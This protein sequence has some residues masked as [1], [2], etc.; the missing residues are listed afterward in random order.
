[1]IP[2]KAFKKVSDNGNTAV[3]KHENGHEIHIVKASLS[4]PLKKQ[5]QEM[6][7]HSADGN[8]IPKAED[9]APTDVAQPQPQEQGLL[10]A[11]G[12]QGTPVPPPPPEG[13]TQGAAIGAV[14]GTQNLPPPDPFN[15][16]PG[17]QEQAQAIP[18]KES[19]ISDEGK[20][21]A[22][23]A[24]YKQVQDYALQQQ[25]QRNLQDK[26]G[27]IDAATADVRAGHIK[28]NDYLDSM[29]S[30]G[31]ISTAIGLILGG[32]GSGMTG[33]GN[34]ALSFL[35]SQ[36]E[37]NIEAQKA[38]MAN[39]H[40]LLS[41]LGQQY[42]NEIERDTMFRAINANILA[43]QIQEAA[44]KSQSQ[45]AKAA[46]LQASGML[47]SQYLPAL[48]QMEWMKLAGAPVPEVP[49]SVPSK[50]QG[51]ASGNNLQQLDPSELVPH[52]VPPEHQKEVFNEI[53]IAQTASK[54]KE[55][56]LSTFDKL[57]EDVS[58]SK[59]PLYATILTS[60]NK[61][62][63]DALNDPLIRDNEGRINEFEKKD[64]ENLLPQAGDTA[65][66]IA[67]KRKHYEEFINNKALAPTAKGFGIDLQKYQSTST[68][69]G[70]V[71]VI[72]PD[73]RLGSIPKTQLK[74]A[75]AQG[76]KE[77]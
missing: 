67:I 52:L 20:V 59:H 24:H 48:Q 42:H 51:Q 16:I 23:A 49:G 27:E 55:S 1:M 40:N 13:A 75:V 12:P 60:P 30:V 32:I 33:Q 68:D 6:P 65:A 28:P 14:Q 2:M 7:L 21:I 35:N 66:T 41:A 22:D 44:G 37:R 11:A 31:K 9:N 10:Q 18:T 43:D 3:L 26:Q 69:S 17:Y 34:P 71:K 54:N 46:A 45:M 57:A 38:D 56:M 76:Y 58:F 70:T 72:S 36:I 39:K 53:K 29:S 5:L 77:R 73:G 50:L 25:L 74:A 64:L 61:K 8:K 4:E 62:S 47:K 63:L 19:A 15:S